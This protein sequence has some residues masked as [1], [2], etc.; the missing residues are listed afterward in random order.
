MLNA[1]STSILSYL[2]EESTDAV[3][4]MDAQCIVRFVNGAMTKLSGYGV[5]ELVGE[6]ISGLLPDAVAPH[7]DKYVRD[8]VE[9]AR[10]SIVLG[11]VRE[12]ELRHRTGE[13]IPI[14]LK[15]LDLGTEG[16]IRYFGAFMIDLRR[17]KDS[18]AKNTALVTQLEQQALTDALTGLPNRRAFDLEA[19]RVMAHAKREGWPV[20]VGI[21]D[22]DW[23]KK[24]NDTYGHAAGDTVLRSVAHAVQ[25]LVRGGDLFGRIG[26]EEFG[27]LLPRATTSQALIIAERIRALLADNPIVIESNE[28]IRITISIGLAQWNLDNS[29]ETA[30]ARADAALYQAKLTGRNRIVVAQT[31]S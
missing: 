8:Y 27:L 3:L 17:R 1:L 15:A 9:G 6:S 10:V 25:S 21:A 23:F 4:I 11:R 29:L 5:G 14:E 19:A 12:M 24:V 28:S 16:G 20:T 18:E 22:I 31:A 7:H 2:I 30:L 26:G 13:I